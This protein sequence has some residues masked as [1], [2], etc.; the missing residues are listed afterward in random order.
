MASFKLKEYEYKFWTDSNTK[1]TNKRNRS[2]C[3]SVNTPNDFTP[4][5]TEW[6]NHIPPVCTNHGSNR[7]AW[8]KEYS[9]NLDD[10]Y[11]IVQ[12]IINSKYPRNNIKWNTDPYLKSN[13]DRV[14]YHCSSGHIP[15]Y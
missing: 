15:K 3:T 12:N 8:Q 5:Y 4:K 1:T 7:D 11:E 14:I 13:L 6:G 9:Q 10:I 2:K